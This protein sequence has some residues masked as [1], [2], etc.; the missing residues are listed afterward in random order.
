[1]HHIILRVKEINSL[2]LTLGLLYF[3]ERLI[4]VFVPIYFWEVGFPL[5]RIILFYFL[6]SLYFLAVSLLAIPFMRKM[7]DKSMMLASIP[8]LAAYLWGLRF[9]TE[10]AAFF[11]ILP[12]ML[13]A[14]LVFFNVGYH[15][16]FTGASDGN[17]IGRQIGSRDIVATLTSFSAPFIGGTLIILWGFNSTFAA[18]VAIAFLA[19]LPLF[20]YAQRRVTA[21]LTY[22]ALYDFFKNRDL[23]PFTFSG[24]GYAAEKTTSDVA[25]P[26]FIFLAA[27]SIQNVGGIISLGLLADIII[28]YIAGFMSD[29]GRRKNIITWMSG[30]LSILWLVRPF[31]KNQ[32]PIAANHIAGNAVKAGLYTAWGSQY[33]TIARSFSDPAVFIVS[34]EILYHLAR[35]FFLPILLIFSRMFSL[36]NFFLVS[37]LVTA[38]ISLLFLAANRMVK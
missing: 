13:A 36:S 35:V 2:Y 37:F 16:S 12:F 25:W 14:H 15:L 24:A 20:F 34:R 7:S 26:L 29:Q 10:N 28:Y 23:L 17:H 1:M 38:A 31:L 6:I 5:W 22:T 3:G 9:V 8:S 19:I 18:G 11:Y 32:I 4:S 21:P 30:F 27:G 33:Y